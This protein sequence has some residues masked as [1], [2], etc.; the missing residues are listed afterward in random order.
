[1]LPLDVEDLI[2]H[3]L[4]LLNAFTDLPKKKHLKKLIARSDQ[5]CMNCLAFVLN[6][7]ATQFRFRYRV[8]LNNIFFYF[9][10]D[11]IQRIHLKQLLQRGSVTN[12]A[13]CTLVWI[14]VLRQPNLCDYASYRKLFLRSVLCQLLSRLR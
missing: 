1:M 13:C 2:Y 10:L 7:Q 11:A 14:F 6:Q 4:D 12:F 3:Y 8:C 9:R 5:F